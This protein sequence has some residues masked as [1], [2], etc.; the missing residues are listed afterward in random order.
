VGVAVVENISAFS[1]ACDVIMS[2]RMVPQIHEILQFSKATV[3]VVRWS[4]MISTVYNVVGVGIAASG[5]LAP[6]VCAI[7]MPVSSVTVIAFAC[8]MTAWMGRRIFDRQPVQRNTADNTFHP[9]TPVISTSL[10]KE[11]A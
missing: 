11:A 2:A 6:V 10:T 8:G 9:G 3:R 4:F 5:K 1:P 7:L